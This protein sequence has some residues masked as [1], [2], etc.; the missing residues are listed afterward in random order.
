MKPNFSD[1]DGY[2]KWRMTW[3]KIY[4]QMSLNIIDTKK[5]LK[6]AQRNTDVSLDISHD[7]SKIVVSERKASSGAGDLQK[8]LRF[9]KAD[10]TKLMTLLSEAK[11]RK[12]RII[13]MAKSIKEQPFPLELDKCPT[14]DF[15]FNK[16]SI[17]FPFL[18]SWVVKTKGKTFYV[19]DVVSNH[20]FSTKNKDTGSTRGLLRFK[21]GSLIIDSD[22]IAYINPS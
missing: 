13:E 21:R 22:G 4:K 9:M 17:E 15:H 8:K 10:A 12:N 19:T 14:I 20:T 11:L 18:P 1:R 6:A 2:I 5:K 3:K 16:G 7:N